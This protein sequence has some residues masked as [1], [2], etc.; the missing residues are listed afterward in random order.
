MV[1]DMAA[2]HKHK[3]EFVRGGWSKFYLHEPTSSLQGIHLDALGIEL[4]GY[5]AS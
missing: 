1:L 2:K 3:R 4:S 5:H